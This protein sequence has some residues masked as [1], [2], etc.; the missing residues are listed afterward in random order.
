MIHSRDYHWLLP[1]L[2]KE[3]DNAFAQWDSDLCV[4]FLRFL[5][6]ARRGWWCGLFFYSLHSRLLTT[7]VASDLT[8]SKLREAA[9]PV[10]RR[11]LLLISVYLGGLGFYQSHNHVS[12]Q[13]LCILAS[14]LTSL[15]KKM[16]L[17][18]SSRGKEVD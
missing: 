17:L 2:Y 12:L 4:F 16:L 18:S 14:S 15:W 9:N 1:L 6:L 3:I 7:M 8:D 13:A 11:L 5:T 10:P